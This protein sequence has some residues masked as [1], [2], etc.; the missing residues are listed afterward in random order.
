MNTFGHLFRLSIWGESHGAQ[1]GVT[2]D[3]VPPGLPLAESDFEADLARRRAG[4]AGTTPRRERY[5][6]RIV[7]GLYRG[8]TT[9]TRWEASSNAGCRASPQGWA[10][11]FSTRPRA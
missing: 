2:L 3:G 6:P 7:S 8:R 11:P 5:L 1:I 10:S 9:A 4:A